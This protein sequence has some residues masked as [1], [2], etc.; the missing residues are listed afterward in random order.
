M[1][2][3]PRDA[4]EISGYTATVAVAGSVLV[5]TNLCAASVFSVPLC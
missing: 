4:S 2:G 3:T 5:C 1:T